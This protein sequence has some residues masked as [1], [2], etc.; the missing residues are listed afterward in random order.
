MDK[1]VPAL[2]K[3]YGIYTNKSKML[4]N[5][6][7]GLLPVQRRI[8]L[9]AHMIAKNN[10][11]KT[12][13]LLGEC[14]SR[15]HPHKEA[16][17]TAAWAV[18]NNFILGEGQWGSKIGTEP[19]KYASP[20]YTKI[21]S[22]PFIEKL[23]FELIRYVKWE[24]D[25]MDPEPIAIPTMIPFCLFT[26]YDIVSIAFGYKTEIPCFRFNDLINRLLFLNNKQKKITPKPTVNG[27]TI[28]SNI[29]ECESLITTGNG[30]LD[31]QGKFLINNK[32]KKVIIKGWNPRSTFQALINKIN[33]YK[34]W[35][36]LANED[37]GFIDQSNEKNGTTVIFEVIK[38]RNVETI[39]KKLVE[40]IETSLKSTINFNI[41]MTDYKGRI[42]FPS[43]DEILQFTYK[44]YKEVLRTY[45]EKMILQSNNLI[46]EFEI[47]Q[48]VKPHI[49]SIANTN[50]K[51]GIKNLSFKSG[52]SEKDLENLINKYKIKKL[53]TATIDV[54]ELK[55]NIS[56]IE[57]NLKNIDNVLIKKYEDM[58]LS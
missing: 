3:S 2:Y 25:E 34:N 4:P 11:V 20:R 48:K 31:I 13:K 18:Q 12:A 5:I 53:L 56:R 36:L 44:F 9:T 28:L 10:F 37:V 7:D 1:L 6:I 46:S 19:I 35:N 38:Q 39:F 43:I 21:K 41:V 16:D 30:K 58:R 55:K 40:A 26:K 54:V 57:K 8:L 42:L 22:N 14:M 24:A 15:W 52:V 23:A 47:I 51:K 29:K 45:F 27:C 49:S 17:G 50:I 33:N 32:N